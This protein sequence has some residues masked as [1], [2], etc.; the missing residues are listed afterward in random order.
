M[1]TFDYSTLLTTDIDHL[2]NTAAR[3][4]SL[5]AA[6]TPGALEVG[7]IITDAKEKLPH[8]KFGPWCIEALGIDRRRAQIYMNLAKFAK[9]HGREQIQKL[10]LKAAHYVA[11]RSV[12]ASVALEVM[13]LVAAGNIPTAADIKDLIREGCQ[14]DNQPGY[15]PEADAEALSALLSEALA[16]PSLIRLAIFL[17]EATP[18][19]IRELGRKLKGIVPVDSGYQVAHGE[20]G[21]SSVGVSRA[22]GNG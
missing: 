19:A 18:R 14:A 22:V 3:A 5:L 2:R 6:V 15:D 13:N 9:V 7:E 8:G 16:P 12:P 17:D 1:D 20:F 10:P 11:A 21:A 4:R